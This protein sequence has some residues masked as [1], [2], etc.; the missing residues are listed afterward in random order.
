MLKKS[1]HDV[2]LESSEVTQ[3][4]EKHKI[5]LLF[6]YCINCIQILVFD[7]LFVVSSV[8]LNVFRVFRLLFYCLCLLGFLNKTVN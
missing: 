3:H 4:E 1:I 6:K 5:D 7:T 8:F 2:F